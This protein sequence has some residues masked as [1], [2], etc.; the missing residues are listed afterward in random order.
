MHR[1]KI[2]SKISRYRV[3]L[4]NN[5]YVLLVISTFFYA[6]GFYFF[7]WYLPVLI[8]QKYG[9]TYLS[10]TYIFGTA[11]GLLAVISGIISDILGYKY[12]IIGV[13]A[14]VALSYATLFFRQNIFTTLFVAIALHVT[15]LG[16]PP[17]SAL[18]SM[19]SRKETLGMAFSLYRL[20]ML[21]GFTVSSML[22]AIITQIFGL[23]ST[24]LLGML[25]IAIC[26]IA[27][28]AVLKN[29]S[30]Y[31]NQ[32]R[33]RN[34]I[35]KRLSVHVTNMFRALGICG[36]LA[37]VSMSSVNALALSYGP[38]LY[39]FIRDVLGLSIAFL[40]IYQSVV[41]S[42]TATSQPISGIIV[43]HMGKKAFKYA[44]YA[45]ILVSAII[46][47]LALFIIRHIFSLVFIGVTLALILLYEL[48]GSVLSNAIQ[49]TVSSLSSRDFRGSSYGLLTSLS[50]LIAIPLYPVFA[51]VWSVDP[52]LIPLSYGLLMLIPLVMMYVKDN[53][54]SS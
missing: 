3:L 38:F 16:G 54:C 24:L 10:I 52:A 43:D 37:F 20:A 39:N 8:M 29:V 45:E 47:L 13:P 28:V 35:N 44:I 42:L 15:P 12:L 41:T 19:I 48:T 9:A 26:I 25:L 27:R 4:S 22:M 21:V 50:S 1:Y 30:S 2:I 11:A 5:L 17:V 40:G 23:S 32:T 46:S 51:Y 49:V 7:T 31:N 6:I 34:R 53:L 33:D 14:L 18:V 36:I